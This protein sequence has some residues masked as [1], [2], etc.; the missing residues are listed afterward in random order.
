MGY[1]INNDDRLQNLEYILL[2]LEVQ[3]HLSLCQE[4]EERVS[5]LHYLNSLGI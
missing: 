1:N 3:L 2:C 5:T 4:K